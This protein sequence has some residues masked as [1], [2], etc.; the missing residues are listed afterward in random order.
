MRKSKAR[1]TFQVDRNSGM[2]AHENRRGLR[3]CTTHVRKDSELGSLSVKRGETWRGAGQGTD[4]NRS[5]IEG[6]T[7]TTA[8]N[9]LP[10]R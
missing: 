3:K 6:S 8:P 7:W 2:T 1:M 10:Q 4:D 5:V 9:S